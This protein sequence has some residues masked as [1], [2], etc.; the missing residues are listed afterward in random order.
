MFLGDRCQLGVGGD[1][2][3]TPYVAPPPATS[4]PTGWGYP[5]WGEGWGGCPSPPLPT[6]QG[7]PGAQQPPRLDTPTD[8]IGVFSRQWSRSPPPPQHLRTGRQRP[9]GH[10][11]HAGSDRTRQHCPGSPGSSPGQ[12]W[13]LLAQPEGQPGPTA[14]PPRAAPRPRPAPHSP[15]PPP[16]TPVLPAGLWRSLALQFI[17]GNHENTANVTEPRRNYSSSD[18]SRHGTAGTSPPWWMVAPRS[19]RPGP[20]PTPWPQPTPAACGLAL[21]GVTGTWRVPP[22]RRQGW[23]SPRVP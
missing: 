19:S 20:I 18:G 10:A 23:P 14:S 1:G 8:A 13:P 4:L 16:P 2:T 11:E 3:P 22:E 9:R 5:A 6:P 7:C 17:V 21:S 15:P 12:D